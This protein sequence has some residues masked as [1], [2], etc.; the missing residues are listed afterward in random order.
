MRDTSKCVHGGRATSA[1]WGFLLSRAIRE[2]LRGVILRP[3]VC[4][5]PDFHP[6]NGNNRIRCIHQQRVHLWVDLTE[7]EVLI[8]V[9]LSAENTMPIR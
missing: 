5:S 3:E 4:S 6:P 2:I 8:E 9:A 7:Y 1:R